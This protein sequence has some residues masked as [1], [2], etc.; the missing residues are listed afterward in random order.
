MI[1]TRN[2]RFIAYLLYSIIYFSSTLCEDIQVFDTQ[3]PQPIEQKS[4]KRRLRKPKENTQKKKK[5]QTY[6]D[7]SYDE[8]LVAKNKQK[9]GGN[10][11]ATL[12]YLEQ[13]MK[14]TTDID[15][16]A[17][18]LLEM[19]DLLFED[20]QYKKAQKIYNQYCTLY[21]GSNKQEYAMYRSIL[22]LSK[23]ILSI[24]RD[25]TQTE[26]TIA[27]ANTFLE[28]DFS[29]YRNEVLEIQKQCYE[30]L[31]ESE[32]SICSFYIT[33]KK[34]N[35]AEKRIAK[36]RE[37]WLPKLPE[38]EQQVIALEAQLS[39]QKEIIVAKNNKILMAN[40]NK[41]KHMADRF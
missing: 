26:E 25:Q 27:L 24:D 3:L 1:K 38:K 5:I 12:K 34:I 13:L 31:F 10:I 39:E 35:P 21:P 14:L 40:N 4:R 17:E 11:S 18:H 7:M 22:S 6:M 41:S 16:I 29:L 37:T 2:L 36:I 19:A 30:Y 15:Q 23:T 20:K 8:L 32:C 33:H 9:E 28:Q